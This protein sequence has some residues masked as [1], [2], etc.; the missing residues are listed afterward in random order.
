MT[1][2]ST[3]LGS[4]LLP[5]TS[6]LQT[7]ISGKSK[8]SEISSYISSKSIPQSSESLK[9][10]SELSSQ[11][12][13]TLNKV[14]ETTL[15]ISPNSTTLTF[16]S[17]P[18]TSGLQTQI[19]GNIVNS[20]IISNV[21]NN[22]NIQTSGVIHQT[23]GSSTQI[24]GTSNIMKKLS[25]ITSNSTT[26][27]SEPLTQITGEIDKSELASHIA[28]NST[29]LKSGSLTQISGLQTQLTHTIDKSEVSSYITSNSTN[30]ILGSTPQTSLESSDNPSRTLPQPSGNSDKF[31]TN[32]INTGTEKVLTYI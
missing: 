19:S 11:I 23:I 27:L 13:G 8:Y 10:I 20:E 14:K 25:H 32:I 6:R 29:I 1:S 31:N 7:Q 15:P 4:V 28:S 3:N 12:L 5:Q 17:V 30:L 22:P 16:G 18:M 21:Q 26:L 2:F 9:K 24:A